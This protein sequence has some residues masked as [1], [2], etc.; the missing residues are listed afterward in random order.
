MKRSKHIRIRRIALGLAVAAVIPATAQAR[1]LETSG[2]AARAIHQSSSLDR[3]GVEIPYLSHGVGVS[4]S[5]FGQA[6]GPDD[7]SYSRQTESPTVPS[8]HGGSSTDLGK[9]NTVGGLVL[10][11]AAVGTAFAIRQNRKA[12]LSP[13]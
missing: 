8:A 5:D 2:S 12:K 7:R 6:L 4:T 1:P 10:I 11:L 9:T 13:A 3:G